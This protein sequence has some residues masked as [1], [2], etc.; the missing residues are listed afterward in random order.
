MRISKKSCCLFIGLLI[1]A[2]TYAQQ[3]GNTPVSLKTLLNSVNRNA[4]TLL[5]D[6]AA[7][8][9][10]QA[11]AAETRSSWLPNLKLNY[12][13][14]YGTNNNVAGPYFGFGIIPSNSRGYGPKAIPPPF[15]PTLG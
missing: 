1:T 3:Q 10:R 12:Q 11:Q 5:T 6:S 15:Q 13:A 7:I 14:D 9:V 2:Y 4:P 8:A